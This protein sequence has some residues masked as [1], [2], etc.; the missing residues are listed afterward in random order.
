MCSRAASTARVVHAPGHRRRERRQLGELVGG[1]RRRHVRQRAR[2]LVDQRAS[3]RVA[4]RRRTRRRRG[5]RRRRRVEEHVLDQVEA[6]AEVVE[7]GDVAGERQHR[8]GQPEVVGRARR[9]GARS[10]GRRRSRGSRRR[11]R[12]TAAA[13]RCAAPGTRASSASSAAS[14]PWSV[15]TPGGGVPSNSTVAPAHDQRE[16]GIAADEREPAPALARARPTRAGTRAVVVVGP[17][18][19]TNAETG[20]SRSASTSRH[21]G[22]TVW[23]RAERDGTRRATAGP[24]S[25]PGSDGPGRGAAAEGPE[26]A[27]ALAGVA[28][29]AALLLDHEEQRRRRRSRSSA[30]RT[31]WRSPEVSPLHQYSWRLRLQNHVRPVSSVRRSAPR[32]SRRASAPG[33]C[34]PPARSRRPGRRRCTRRRRAPRRWPRSG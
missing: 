9:A 25:S 20:V 6:L 11:R 17:T 30:S 16:R 29:A 10:R 1:R 8:V 27:A 4:A 3:S 21:T 28:G 23:S 22:T 31:H 19:F 5:A 26:E 12:G 24:R 14:A 18:S 7:R 32:S 13:R 33:R 15:G 34:P 2:E